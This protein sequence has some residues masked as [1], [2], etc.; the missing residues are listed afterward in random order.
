M[1][2]DRQRETGAVATWQSRCKRGGGVAGS[3]QLRQAQISTFGRETVRRQGP[4]IRRNSLTRREIA[5]ATDESGETIRRSPSGGRGHPGERSRTC[6]APT[7]QEAYRRQALCGADRWQE[8][9]G[10]NRAAQTTRPLARLGRRQRSVENIDGQA[11]FF[12]AGSIR[13]SGRL[14]RGHER[15]GKP[16]EDIVNQAVGLCLFR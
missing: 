16:F 6:L 2:V 11:G 10:R 13:A 4:V 14:R 7:C 12:A 15:A 5:R 8:A 9:E 1:A 3:L